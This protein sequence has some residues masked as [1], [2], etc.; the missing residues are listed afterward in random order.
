MNDPFHKVFGITSIGKLIMGHVGSVH[1]SLGIEDGKLIK[2]A[3]L[4]AKDSLVQYIKYGAVEWFLKSYSTF[5]NKYSTN[6]AVLLEEAFIRGDTRILEVLLANPCMTLDSDL[7]LS[8]SKRFVSS[9]SSCTHPRWEWILS[10]Y[11]TITC[12]STPSQINIR[13][14]LELMELIKHPSFIKKLI[15]LGAKLTPLIAN[16]RMDAWFDCPWALE[17]FQVLFDNDLLP[18]ACIIKL[19]GMAAAQNNSTMYHHILTTSIQYIDFFFEFSPEVLITP[20]CQYGRMDI[21]NLTFNQLDIHRD[22]IVWKPNDNNWMD[23]LT[24]AAKNGHTTM[25]VY[26]YD[27]VRTLMYAPN[28]LLEATKVAL[29]NGHMDVVDYLLEIL[30]SFDPAEHII[31][32]NKVHQSILSIGLLDRLV[33]HANTRPRLDKVMKNAVRARDKDAVTYIIKG[34]KLGQSSL[35]F[36]KGLSIAIALCQLDLASMIKDQFPYLRVLAPE[37]NSMI[38]FVG[39]PDCP[40]SE[41]DAI[42]FV[43]DTRLDL[44]PNQLSKLI[45]SASTKSLAFIQIVVSRF[46]AVCSGN[47]GPF[48]EIKDDDMKE[49]INEYRAS[50]TMK[51]VWSLPQEI[52][53]SNISDP[54]V[55]EFLLDK[56][57]HNLSDRSDISL[58]LNIWLPEGLNSIAIIWNNHKYKSCSTP[59]S[60]NHS[61]KGT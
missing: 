49:A 39:S 7:S 25:V 18:S 53:P 1:R 6:N 3:T 45:I 26:L 12:I 40:I 16:T 35:S 21:L 33:A 5:S 58:T 8:L 51:T 43:K 38:R 28:C 31:T 55:L 10:E 32:L 36:Q 48:V 14:D 11:L 47:G 13:I 15:K 54:V 59:S 44:N 34:L 57:Y 37:L 4:L 30:Q 41:E 9:L 22:I 2:G 50:G 56:G 20:C 27:H 52:I 42:N 46:T 23:W 17:M 61:T 19:L 29:E 60:F 24:I